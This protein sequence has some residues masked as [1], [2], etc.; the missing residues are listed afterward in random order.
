M[1]DSNMTALRAALDESAKLIA[2]I[3]ELEAERDEDTRAMARFQAASG[4]GITELAA[5]GW[6]LVEHFADRIAALDTEAST[7]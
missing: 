3:A 6:A 1:T 5:A 7:P 2:R 4:Q